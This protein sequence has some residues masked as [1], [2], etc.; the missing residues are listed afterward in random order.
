LYEVL[1]VLDFMNQGSHRRLMI[2]GSA[3]VWRNKL[4]AGRRM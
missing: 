2:R 3:C 4:S 1:R